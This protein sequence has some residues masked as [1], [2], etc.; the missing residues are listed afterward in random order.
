MKKLS[1]ALL[2][3]ASILVLSA[4]PGSAQSVLNKP[5]PAVVPP[6]VAPPSLANGPSK[7]LVNPNGGGI[8][9][10]GAGNIV[11]SGAGNLVGRNSN[12]LINNGGSTLRRP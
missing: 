10:S 6:K 12:S 1:A 8:V 2:A 3:A 4:L 5:R 7:N 11:A 9:A